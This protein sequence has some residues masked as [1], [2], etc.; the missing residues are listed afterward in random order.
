MKA[1]VW[2][3]FHDGTIERIEKLIPG[4]FIL[5]LSGL[6][7]LQEASKKYLSPSFSPAHC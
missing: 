5:S 3:H 7:L 2:G 1:D 6:Y 4:E